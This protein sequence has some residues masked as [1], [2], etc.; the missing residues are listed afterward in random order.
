VN[1]IK[2]IELKTDRKYGNFLIHK[3]AEAKVSI[4]K[5]SGNKAL[6]E[7]KDFIS[8]TIIERLNIDS[9]L[10]KVKIPDFRSMID[11]V[12]I[13]NNYDGKV[14]HIVYSDVLKERRF[15]QGQ[16]RNRIA[17][18]KSQGSRQNHR[19]ARRRNSD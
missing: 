17:E 3:P 13:D 18:F 5:L 6:V 14:F 1:K 8:P 2:V 4:K 9:G 15:S 11:T 12:L 7:I 16:I 10:F 19:Y